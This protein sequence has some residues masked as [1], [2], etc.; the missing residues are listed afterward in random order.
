MKIDKKGGMTVYSS[1]EIRLNRDTI[2]VLSKTKSG[3]IHMDLYDKGK[4][5]TGCSVEFGADLFSGVLDLFK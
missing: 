4:G 3:H 1:K 5:P 2:G